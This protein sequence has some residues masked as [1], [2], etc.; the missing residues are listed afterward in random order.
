[1][2]L[3]NTENKLLVSI[4]ESKGYVNIEDYIITLITKECTSVLFKNLLTDLENVIIQQKLNAPFNIN[5]LIMDD[6][7]KFVSRQ[8][9]E[10]IEELFNMYIMQEQS[11]FVVVQT[12][13]DF[14]NQVQNYIR[15]I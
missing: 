3:N 8:T 15:I 4:A 9:F 12:E 5:D 1:M 6:D 13:Y 2:T 11:K 14:K 7:I 10:E